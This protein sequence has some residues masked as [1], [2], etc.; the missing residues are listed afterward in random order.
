MTQLAASS[1]IT[2]DSQPP[3]SPTVS[4]GA[5]GCSPRSAGHA[6]PVT[7]CST[8]M[9]TSCTVEGPTSVVSTLPTNPGSRVALAELQ[10]TQPTLVTADASNDLKTCFTGPQTAAEQATDG[11][12][13]T[14]YGPMQISAQVLSLPRSITNCRNLSRPLTLCYAGRQVIVPPSCIVLSAEGAKLLLPPQTVVPSKPPPDPVDLSCKNAGS[15]SS[16]GHLRTSGLSP[17]LPSKSG[18]ASETALSETT[19]SLMPLSAE[20]KDKAASEESTV[21]GVPAIEEAQPA[22]EA[23]YLTE[24]AS[25]WQVLSNEEQ[26]CVADRCGEIDVSRLNDRSLV[27]I[28]TFLRLTDLLRAS[29]VCSRWNAIARDPSLVNHI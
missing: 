22:L 16:T 13:R 21:T 1:V 28:F 7:R 5:E 15:I 24:S 11:S 2:A 23:P 10:P 20:C 12:S 18:S 17:V 19:D 9:V 14:T 4:G 26:M 27:R 3:S 6:F 29:L 8:V 25:D